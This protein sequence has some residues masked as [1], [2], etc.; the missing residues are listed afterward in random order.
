MD[1]ESTKYLC[2][3]LQEADI[4]MNRIAYQDDTNQALRRFKTNII[5]P[6]VDAIG[7]R[8]IKATKTHSY[9]TTWY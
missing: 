3:K 1:V 4:M 6:T 5:Q 2:R 8:N 9:K 7:I